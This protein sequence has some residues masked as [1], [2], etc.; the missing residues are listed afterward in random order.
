MELKDTID[1]ML[2]DDFRDRL[3]AEYEQLNI[4]IQKLEAA[5]EHWTKDKNKLSRPVYLPLLRQQIRHMKAYRKVLSERMWLIEL[6]DN[7]RKN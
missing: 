4:R 6:N 2:S 7:A 3:K 5:I 1:L